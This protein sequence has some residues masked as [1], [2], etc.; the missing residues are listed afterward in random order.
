ML[1]EKIPLFILT[2]AMFLT[3][4]QTFRTAVGDNL[5][6]VRTPTVVSDPCAEADWFEVGRVDALKGGQAENSVY[7]G[8]C[9]HLGYTPNFELYEAGWQKGLT[10]YCTPEHGF[11]AGRMGF[12]YNGICPV[13]L[14]PSF[15]KRFKV[16]AEIA[17]LEK[18]N[19]K[20]D[21]EIE[22]NLSLL[23]DLNPTVTSDKENQI[24]MLRRAR[25]QNE[26][27]I[28]RLETSG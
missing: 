20:I 8:R 26:L 5:S 18:E 21:Q 2:L 11:D 4:C 3:G 28:R 15:L 1:F 23:D 25:A 22:E 13:H 17:K 16:G 7:L 9:T 10:E 12:S 19:S 6:K 14:E 24:K 27:E